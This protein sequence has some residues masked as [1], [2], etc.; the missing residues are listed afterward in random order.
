MF[1]KWRKNKRYLTLIKTKYF[2]IYLIIDFYI[3]LHIFYGNKNK[4]ITISKSGI[5]FIQCDPGG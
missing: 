5:K 1:Q 2:S 3:A 4:M